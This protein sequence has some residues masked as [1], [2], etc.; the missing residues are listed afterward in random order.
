[1]GRGG[2]GAYSSYGVVRRL[3]G[4]LESA[5]LSDLVNVSVFAEVI[6]LKVCHNNP[7]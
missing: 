1:M 2:R 7:L 6:N 4:D 3:L 5:N